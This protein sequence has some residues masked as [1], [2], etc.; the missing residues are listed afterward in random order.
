M[1]LL[2]RPQFLKILQAWRN[3]R[4][5]TALNLVDQFFRGGSGSRS[6]MTRC[7][8]IALLCV[9]ENEDNRPTMNSVVLMLSDTSVSMPM[10]STPAFMVSST[11][12]QL[13]ASP[14]SLS[15]SSN[16][17]NPNQFTRNEVSIST[18]DPR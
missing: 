13:E 8:H 18:L 16:H 10:P 14:S 12:V 9:Q 2:T 4:E 15:S 1:W 3:W 6:E 17:I 11:T 7:I 5:G